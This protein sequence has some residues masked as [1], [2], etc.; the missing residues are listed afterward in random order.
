MFSFCSA[1]LLRYARKRYVSFLALLCQWSN[2]AL[3]MAPFGFLNFAIGFG[4]GTSR[5]LDLI[6]GVQRLFFWLEK[7]LST[8]VSGEE[9]R[10]TWE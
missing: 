4:L 8:G 5:P 6:L 10:E 7:G 1:S 3:L 9:M 2:Q